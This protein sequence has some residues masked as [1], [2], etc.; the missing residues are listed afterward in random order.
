MWITSLTTS[1]RELGYVKKTGCLSSFDV[2]VYAHSSHLFWDAK[3]LTKLFSRSV[4]NFASFG[5]KKTKQKNKMRFRKSSYRGRDTNDSQEPEQMFK[6]ISTCSSIMRTTSHPS[7][8]QK[9][10]VSKHEAGFAGRGQMSIPI[11]TLLTCSDSFS[12]KWG[13]NVPWP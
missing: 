2:E 4:W 1:R 10:K 7:G 11:S 13:K 6:S 5:C 12:P 3:Q 8:W 9:P